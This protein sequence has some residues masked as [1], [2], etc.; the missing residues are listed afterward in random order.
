MKTHN[1]LSLLLAFAL[2]V[3]AYGTPAQEAASDKLNL[4]VLV[5]GRPDGER[6]ADFVEFLTSHVSRVGV[7]SYSDF[8]PSDADGW[9][10]VIFDAEVRPT[11]GTIGLPK[12]PTL[13]K[14]FRRASL[15]MHGAGVNAV[16]TLNP[17][18]DWL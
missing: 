17:K 7:A 4:S 13:P 1:A 10:V 2:G 8:T 9:D 5:T 6:R 11:V 16:A 3:P 12:P 14:S 15:L 18:I